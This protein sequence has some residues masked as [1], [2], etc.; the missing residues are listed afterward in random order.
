MTSHFHSML[1]IVF[2]RQFRVIMPHKCICSVVFIVLPKPL[3]GLSIS[4]FLFL[5]Q[6]REPKLYLNERLVILIFSATLLKA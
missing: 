5:Y 2:E 1:D 6:D 3:V 4:N